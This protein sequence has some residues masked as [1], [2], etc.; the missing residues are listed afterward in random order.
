L[1]FSNPLERY[2]GSNLSLSLGHD[3][4]L[5]KNFLLRHKRSLINFLLFLLHN[6]IR[7]LL[8]AVTEL[9]MRTFPT[10]FLAE[11]KNTTQ[12]RV[13]N[14]CTLTEKGKPLYE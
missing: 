6:P 8:C 14:K 2:T 11:Q 12:A 7:S 13:Y 3:V 9:N 4:F 1:N 5:R 10:K